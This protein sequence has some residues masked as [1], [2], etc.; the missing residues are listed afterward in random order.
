MGVDAAGA[1][2]VEE[3]AGAGGIGGMA[4][5]ELRIVE[6]DVLGLHFEDGDFV[7]A[8]TAAA[9]TALEAIGVL[10]VAGPELGVTPVIWG[11]GT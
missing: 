6:T 1:G 5:Q 7:D 11:G 3:G 2:V 8:A 9:G 4:S 10:S